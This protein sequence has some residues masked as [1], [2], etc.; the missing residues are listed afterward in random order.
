MS[1]PFAVSIGDCVLA[2]TLF[3]G[4]FATMSFAAVPKTDTGITI[5][6][7]YDVRFFDPRRLK[8]REE[9][10]DALVSVFPV[11]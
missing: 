9:I 1:D 10:V 2:Q 5:R 7:P 4:Q 11:P 3:G 6:Y 8:V